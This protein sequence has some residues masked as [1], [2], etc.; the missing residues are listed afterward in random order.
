MIHSV[1]E[2]ADVNI[3]SV[4]DTWHS[5]THGNLHATG[6]RY[7]WCCPLGG[8]QWNGMQNYAPLDEIDS[9]FQ[10]YCLFYYVV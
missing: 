6:C 9:F 1:D 3:R 4:S 8:M 2:E 10:V 7:Q 5:Y